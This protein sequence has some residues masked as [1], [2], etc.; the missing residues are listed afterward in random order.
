MREQKNYPE[1]ISNVLVQHGCL[2]FISNKSAL[3]KG[4]HIQV[5]WKSKLITMQRCRNPYK[6]VLR[7]EYRLSLPNATTIQGKASNEQ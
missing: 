3:C 7:F 2:I 6:H 4:H 1:T 5:A